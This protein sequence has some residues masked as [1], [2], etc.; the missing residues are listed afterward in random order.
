MINANM[1]ASPSRSRL[2]RP[3]P[4]RRLKDCGV[5]TSSMRAE[6]LTRR[7]PRYLARPCPRPEALRPRL[8]A[9]LPSSNLDPQATKWI[10]VAD[11]VRAYETPFAQ[12]LQRVVTRRQG[13]RGCVS[14]VPAH[15]DQRA[16]RLPG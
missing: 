16:A 4:L 7:Q 15:A 5:L 10:V 3:R 8:A 11:V 6:W 12:L 13:S 1:G 9:G 2:E 14:R